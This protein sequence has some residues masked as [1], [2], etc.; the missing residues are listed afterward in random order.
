[1]NKEG[2]VD[3]EGVVEETSKS[4]KNKSRPE[5]DFFVAGQTPGSTETGNAEKQDGKG[6]GEKESKSE[7]FF[8]SGTET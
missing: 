7:S 2:K 6:D 5:T 3:T 4:N 1:M 8:V